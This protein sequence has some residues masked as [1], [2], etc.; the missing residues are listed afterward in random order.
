M[1]HRGG[2]R[3]LSSDDVLDGAVVDVGDIRIALR[4][5]DAARAESVASLFRHATL[6]IGDP[7]I[8]L[9]FDAGSVEPP[10]G[11]PTTVTAHAD[12]WHIGPDRLV[13]RT[14]AGMT[15]TSAE[16]AL[17]VVGGG[18]GMAREFRFAA[19]LGLTHLLAPHDRHLLHGGAVLLDAGALVVL[20]GTGTGKSTMAY[21]AH[22]LG[23]PVLADDA[24]LVRRAG[25]DVVTAGV[26]RPMAVATDVVAAVADGR[27][28]P[29]D[30]RARTELPPGTLTAGSHPAVGIVVT[31]GADPRGQRLDA[32]S[33]VDAMH[34]VL[35]ASASLADHK[36][37]P[38]LFDVAGALARLPAWSVRHGT[39]P[40]TAIADATDQLRTLRKWLGNSA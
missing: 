7:V 15:A 3:A 35:R 19:L 38:A 20:G 4:A 30:P 23:W 2:D 24:V 32:L 18:P 31:T 10:E 21:A 11:A 1:K 29:E 22:R 12:F 16:D 39:D 34:A 26:P 40:S 37:R 36:A 6:A 25:N 5:S 14:R 8:E 33:G 28:V 17:V 13:V 27:P 9:R